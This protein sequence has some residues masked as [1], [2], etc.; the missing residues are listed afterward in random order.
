MYPLE[1]ERK[2]TP[3]STAV[4]S[5]STPCGVTELLQIETDAAV[6]GVNVSASAAAMVRPNVTSARQNLIAT[7]NTS[8][9]DPVEE[10]SLRRVGR[11]IRTGRDLEDRVLN[12]FD[13]LPRERHRAAVER[14]RG[15]RSRGDRR[16]D[17]RLETVRAGTDRDGEAQH[18]CIPRERL[19]RRS[20]ATVEPAE[21][22][23]RRNHRHASRL[24]GRHDGVGAGLSGRRIEV[25]VHVLGGRAVIKNEKNGVFKNSI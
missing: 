20:V 22:L 8:Y 25:G 19:E 14:D 1:S 7:E 2:R 11:L 15:E 10:R 3:S 16:R 23:F 5:L 18:V 13:D 9:M 6:A 12:P 21:K 4:V 17:H 24:R